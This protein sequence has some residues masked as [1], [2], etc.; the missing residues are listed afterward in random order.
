MT[1]NG[2]AEIRADA[3]RI[4]A[5]VIDRGR[6][7]DE[8][9]AESKDE[10]SVRGLKRSLCYGT[11]R[12]HFR[13]FAILKA[14][15]DRSPDQLQ[16]R[17]RALLEIGLQQLIAG[18]T[19]PH[20]AVSETVSAARVLG[21]EKAAGFV[22]A[23]LR[24][25]QRE[26]EDVLH[27]VD[28]DLALRTAHPR[29]IVEALRKERGG[30]APYEVLEANNAHPPLWLRVN[31]MRTDRPASVAALE[32]AGFKAEPHPWAPDAILVSPPTDVPQPAG[33]PRGQPVGAGRGRATGRRVARPAARR[34]DPRRLRGA[35]RQDLPRAR[36][37]GGDG[38]PARR[39][40][41]RPAG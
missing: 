25:F 2:P 38:R 37:H 6:S 35:R 28:R 3:A 1:R 15:T 20:A 18:E 30:N 33:L 41:P 14:L 31:R 24:R 11:L 5:E 29:W 23:V 39:S 9:L 32:A 12:W 26:Q 17:L 36:A 27:A 8:L 19:P 13:L 34:A 22:N 21:F 7:L 10:G 16:P 40:T 4:V